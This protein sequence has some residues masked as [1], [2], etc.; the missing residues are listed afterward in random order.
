M[1]VGIRATSGDAALSSFG[2]VVKYLQESNEQ[3][4]DNQDCCLLLRLDSLSDT[5]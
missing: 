1:A 3:L 2:W 5:R 4:Q